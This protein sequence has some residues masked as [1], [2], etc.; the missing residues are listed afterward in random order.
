L[1]TRAESNEFV[2]R[3]RYWAIK[4]PKTQPKKGKNDTV[5]KIH[6]TKMTHDNHQDTDWGVGTSVVGVNRERGGL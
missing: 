6:V 3:S 5:T 4:I 1:K 2:C